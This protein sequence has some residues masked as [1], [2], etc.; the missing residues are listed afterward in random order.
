MNQGYVLSQDQIKVLLLGKG[1]DALMAIGYDDSQPDDAAVLQV[2]NEL[3]RQKLLSVCGDAFV[4]QPELREMIDIIGGAQYC[5]TVIPRETQL[6]DKCL[7]PGK[8]L[9]CCT[10]RP[11]DYE[12]I[13]LDFV[14]IDELIGQ[15]YDEGYLPDRDEIL[16]LSDERAEEYEQEAFG[17]LNGG[18][19]DEASPVLMEIRVLNRDGRIDSVL[20]VLDYFYSRYIRLCLHGQITRSPFSRFTMIKKMTELMQNDFS[21]D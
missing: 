10:I 9:L 12:H 17:K 8:H 21:R 2:L 16:T 11:R 3:T 19:P 20:T 14:G 5:M 4:L 15:L 6:P 13:Y 1:Y 7:Y 18:R